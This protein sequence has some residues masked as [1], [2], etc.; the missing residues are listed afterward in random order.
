MTISRKLNLK[1][2]EAY[3]LDQKAY[4]LLNMG[5]YPRSLQT[6]LSGLEIAEDPKS[7]KNVLP[8]KYILKK[9]FSNNR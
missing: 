8:Q 9:D 3:A 7:E 5:D 2:N 1:L 6:F 4:A